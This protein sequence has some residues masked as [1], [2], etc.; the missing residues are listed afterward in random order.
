MTKFTSENQ[1]QRRGRPKGAK[2]KLTKL[3]EN[4]SEAIIKV[5]IEIAKRGDSQAISTLLRY[6]LPA[7]RPVAEPLNIDLG[8]ATSL[9]EKLDFVLTAVCNGEVDPM[10]GTGLV[11]SMASAVKLAELEELEQR[12][13]VME[14]QN[15]A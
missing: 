13:S 12:I 1:P 8:Q 15:S 3:L 9:K 4:E 6:T 14:S 5:A 11:N 7:K 2:N 10:V